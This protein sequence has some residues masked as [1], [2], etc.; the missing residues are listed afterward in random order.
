MIAGAKC[1]LMK[2]QKIAEEKKR[3][4]ELVGFNETTGEK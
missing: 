2:Q 1:D 3:G 4:S